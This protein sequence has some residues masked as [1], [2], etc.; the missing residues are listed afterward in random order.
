MIEFT[1]EV[2][3]MVEQLTTVVIGV[4]TIIALRNNKRGN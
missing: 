3:G 4:M 2:L 1:K